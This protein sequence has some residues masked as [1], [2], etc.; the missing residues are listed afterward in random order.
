MDVYMIYVYDRCIYDMCRFK[1]AKVQNKIKIVIKL[2]K[3][4]FQLK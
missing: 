3:K 1:S 2:T 4:I